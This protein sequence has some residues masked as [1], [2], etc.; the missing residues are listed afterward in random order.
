V[1]LLNWIE[2]I[3]PFL[4]PYHWWVKGA[5]SVSILSFAIGI[6]GLLVTSPDRTKKA[7]GSTTTNVTS[8]SQSGGI[9]ARTVNQSSK[10]TRK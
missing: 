9:T 3:A 7:E 6:I 5:F 10:E 2:A 1:N 4:A 8:Y